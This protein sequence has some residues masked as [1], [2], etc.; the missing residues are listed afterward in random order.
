MRMLSGT[1]AL[2]ALKGTPQQPDA[3][4]VL[5]RAGLRCR[6]MLVTPALTLV[7]PIPPRDIGL[8][9]HAHTATAS[10]RTC[11]TALK[12]SG[13]PWSAQGIFALA[14]PSGHP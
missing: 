4:G 11:A 10:T 13:Y 5:Y 12:P 7:Q 3:S 2:D 14:D 8:P 1:W 6:L 9:T